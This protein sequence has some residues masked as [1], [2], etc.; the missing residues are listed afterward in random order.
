LRAENSAI[1]F[2]EASEASSRPG[3]SDART[4]A[5]TMSGSTRDSSLWLLVLRKKAYAR[6]T[7]PSAARRSP[8]RK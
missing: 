5:A 4:T 3:A 1:R 2:S 6:F 7:A 8:E